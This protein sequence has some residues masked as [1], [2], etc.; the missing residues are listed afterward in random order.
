MSDA[1]IALIRTIVPIIVGSFITWLSLSGVEL[2]PETGAATATALTGLISSAY[3][4]F[5]KFL[6]SNYPAA[7]WLLGYPAQPTYTKE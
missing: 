3:Y 2:D 6:S 5:V 1:I 4:A 7:G